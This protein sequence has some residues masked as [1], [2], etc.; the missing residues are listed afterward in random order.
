ME[1]MKQ[2]PPA[3]WGELVRRLQAAVPEDARMSVNCSAGRVRIY[4]PETFPDAERAREER[5]A[6][7]ER[8]L[9]E[10]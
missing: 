6:M 4:L 10:A 9:Q 8:L 7:W 1:D 2:P 5:R 3:T